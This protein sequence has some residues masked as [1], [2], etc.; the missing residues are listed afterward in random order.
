MQL[1]MV[2]VPSREIGLEALDRLDEAASAGTVSVED[3]ALVY[4]NDKGK[5]KVHQTRDATAGRGAFRGGAIGV[6]VG[7][8]AAPAVVAATAVGAGAGLLIGTTRDSGVSDDRMKQ[9][10]ELI[11][12]SEA[13]LFVLADET[14]AVAITGTVEDFMVGGADVSYEVIPP[15]G[16]RLPPRGPRVR[17]GKLTPEPRGPSTARAEAE[18]GA[19]GL[20][21]DHGGRRQ[22]AVR[23]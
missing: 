7:I 4:R 9:I 2:G 23:S 13:A 12:G 18:E 21:A 16:A 11:E 19:G 1:I 22:P 15:R 14:S 10:G 17:Q 3:A 5:V 20:V 6:L 8:L